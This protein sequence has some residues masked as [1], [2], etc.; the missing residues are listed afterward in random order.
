MGL[1]WPGPITV[2]V[3]DRLTQVKKEKIMQ[4]LS[5]IFALQ[6]ILI[7]YG[8]IGHNACYQNTPTDIRKK[9]IVHIP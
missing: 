4:N 7:N 1:F 5:N 3:S 2:Q 6:K 9:K 8:V